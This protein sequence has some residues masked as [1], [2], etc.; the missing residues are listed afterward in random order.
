MKFLLCI[1]YVCTFVSL[2]LVGGTEYFIDGYYINVRC[3][4]DRKLNID[5]LDCWYSSWLCLLPVV[6]VVVRIVYPGVVVVVVGV[7]I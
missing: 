7:F 2:S 1:R 4:C 5:D 6:F 3:V